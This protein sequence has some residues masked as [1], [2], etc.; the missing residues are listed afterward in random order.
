VVGGG[1]RAAIVVLEPLVAHLCARKH[2]KAAF[3][4]CYG[5]WTVCWTDGSGA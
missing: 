5:A 1:N 2:V 3:V 4:W